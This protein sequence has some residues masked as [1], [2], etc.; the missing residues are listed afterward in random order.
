MN[1][2]LHA[3][4]ISVTSGVRWSVIISTDQVKVR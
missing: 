4:V 3:R 2:E 1:E